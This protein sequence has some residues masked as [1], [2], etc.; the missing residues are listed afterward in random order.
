MS[1]RV[2]ENES[3]T[4]KGGEILHLR[5][6]PG[7]KWTVVSYEWHQKVRY[8]IGAGGLMFEFKQ[9]LPQEWKNREFG[10]AADAAAFVQ[11]QI[12]S[13]DAPANHLAV[14]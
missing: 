11:A 6:E 4:L 3:R 8:D 2:G 5:R 1:D 13:G 12:D 7:R 14:K 9:G 10:S